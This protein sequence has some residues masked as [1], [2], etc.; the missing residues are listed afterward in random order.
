MSQWEF[1]DTVLLWALRVK[2]LLKPWFPLLRPP[3]SLPADCLQLSKKMC[4]LVVNTPLSSDEFFSS[5][6]TLP[7]PY[8]HLKNAF[9]LLYHQTTS[10]CCCRS[11]IM[12]EMAGQWLS[13][14]GGKGSVSCVDRACV[15]GHSQVGWWDC[16]SWEKCMIKCFSTP[17]WYLKICLSGT[18]ERI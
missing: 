13:K 15:R 4:L 5:N 6:F 14:G 2:L 12:R 17:H 11:D 18:S 7:Q 10:Q 3:C 9:S 8:W 16:P 1:S